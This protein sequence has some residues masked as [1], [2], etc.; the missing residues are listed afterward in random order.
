MRKQ[1]ETNETKS[2]DAK[3]RRANEKPLAGRRRQRAGSKVGSRTAS[4]RRRDKA[5]L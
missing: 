1:R 3:R 2:L 5:R 4:L